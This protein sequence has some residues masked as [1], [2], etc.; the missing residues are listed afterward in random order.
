MGPSN[1]GHSPGCPH[2]ACPFPLLAVGD[3]KVQVHQIG[4]KSLQR[5]GD[6]LPTIFG[7][8]KSAHSRV[9]ACPEK[10]LLAL[11]E[12]MVDFPDC[13]QVLE[14]DRIPWIWLVG[15]HV[16]DNVYGTGSLQL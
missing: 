12:A 13:M 2:T 10:M 9:P 7:L 3:V 1:T 11:T 16:E 14:D 6:R 8:V 4:L 5:S 15:T